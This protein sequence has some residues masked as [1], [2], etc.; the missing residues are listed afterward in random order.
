M[1][2]IPSPIERII[3]DWVMEFNRADAMDRTA[4]F[5]ETYRESMLIICEGIEANFP[6]YKFT[7]HT[8]SSHLLQLN[9]CLPDCDP[10]KV[11]SLPETR[12][13]SFLRGLGKHGAIVNIHIITATA[14]P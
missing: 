11:R 3:F 2:R 10:Q 12:V 6:I 13:V 1:D 8:P 5:R 7:I 14:S 9:I 4:A